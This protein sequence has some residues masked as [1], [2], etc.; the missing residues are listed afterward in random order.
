MQHMDKRLTN[1]LQPGKVDI[2]F[3]RISNR[4][5][6]LMRSGNRGGATKVILI[7]LGVL[8]FCVALAVIFVA[9][10]WKTW[11]ASAANAATEN[12][13]KESGLPDDQK[14][15]ILAEIRDLGDNFKSGKIT[16]QQMAQMAKE[17]TDGPLIPLA[18]VQLARHKYIEPSAMT[19]AEKD[20]SILAVQRFARGVYE[21]KIPRNE[22]DDVIAP[23]SEPGPGGRRRLKDTATSTEISQFVANA[24][25]R[26]DAAMVPNEHFDL[27]IA[28][29]LKK[30][31]HGS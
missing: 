26:A 30:A 31:I 23:I 21:K 19:P 15:E 12:M 7:I 11:A 20:A 29:E 4:R 16:T 6:R 9:M 14:N 24:K 27:N 18:G 2:E 5:L 8:V 1:T 22:L 13:V 25:A 10:N 17:I 3:L 28:D